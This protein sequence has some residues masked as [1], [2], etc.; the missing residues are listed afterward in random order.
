[1]DEAFVSATYSY[2]D[3]HSCAT[4]VADGSS[5]MQ[6]LSARPGPSSASG[7]ATYPPDVVLHEGI[8]RCDQ[9][10]ACRAECRGA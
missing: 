2:V 10:A 3:D 4:A 6:M 9:A 5:A 8:F 7:M 1:M